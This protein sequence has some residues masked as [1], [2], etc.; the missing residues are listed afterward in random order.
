MNLNQPK[1]LMCTH[2]S[3]SSSLFKQI[4]RVSQ[5][6][7]GSLGQTF[8]HSTSSWYPLCQRK[9][10]KIRG[11]PHCIWFVLYLLLCWFF[12]IFLC[13]FQMNRSLCLRCLAYI[14]TISSVFCL[15]V[16]FFWSAG[17]LCVWYNLF[18]VQFDLI[19]LYLL[20]N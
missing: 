13:I 1:Q 3:H 12:H 4:F 6:S 17:I 14:S 18:V 11:N 20:W 9:E 5:F 16:S 7:E 2:S 19:L 15:L 8:F 10:E